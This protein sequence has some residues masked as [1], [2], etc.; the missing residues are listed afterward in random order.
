[1]M[2]VAPKNH[3][4]QVIAR[5]RE[6]EAAE[7][8]PEADAEDEAVARSG[9]PVRAVEKRGVDDNVDDRETPPC[10]FV[11]L[12]A[13][14]S[15]TLDAAA[16]HLNRKCDLYCTLGGL[17]ANIAGRAVAVYEEDEVGG[18]VPD[19][20]WSQTAEGLWGHVPAPSAQSA[21]VAR[22]SHHLRMGHRRYTAWPDGLPPVRQ[23]ELREPGAPVPRH[24][25]GQHE[26]LLEQGQ[27]ARLSPSG[28]DERKA[29]ERGAPGEAG[30]KPES[31]TRRT[32]LEI[33]WTG[34]RIFL[35][36][37]FSGLRPWVEKAWDDPA[38]IV[39]LLLPNNRSEQPFFQQ[40]IEPYR[41]RGGSVL[42]TRNLPKRRPFLHMGQGIG[43]RT[44]KN[45]PFGLVVVI[46]DRRDPRARRA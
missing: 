29:E 3:P 4:H 33:N 13:E 30:R 5:Q 1:M 14:F 36:P 6:A 21:E 39:C 40:L 41:D 12:D 22:P 2:G 19:L 45:P 24:E 16:S 17:Y 23:P 44:S 7:G 42:T 32:G 38:D 37:P 34:H 8:E 35:N 9:F 18:L 28:G 31:S 11:P 27:T 15:F 20:D 43:N 10:V 25:L 26:G 46:W